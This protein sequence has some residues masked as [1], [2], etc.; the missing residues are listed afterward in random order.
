MAIWYQIDITLR[1]APSATHRAA[2][3]LRIP[4][5]VPERTKG[6]AC[7]AVK[8]RVQIPPGAQVRAAFEAGGE[9]RGEGDGNLDAVARRWGWGAGAGRG[10]RIPRRARGGSLRCR[11]PAPGEPDRGCLCLAVPIGSRCRWGQGAR[12]Q[13][14]C[15]V[16][17]RSPSADRA[18]IGGRVRRRHP[19]R[20]WARPRRGPRRSRQRSRGCAPATLAGRCRR[21]G[22]RTAARVGQSVRA[23]D[24][25]PCR[26]AS[27]DTNEW[28][29]VHGVR[30]RDCLVRRCPGCGLAP[31]GAT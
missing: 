9:R 30:L 11:G 18:R 27:R 25:H 3:T 8:P 21:L 29:S 20:P 10:G 2:G 15:L 17:L 28:R 7:K 1:A 24:R 12:F 14:R 16:G 4:A 23:R 5:P 13:R 19:V 6:T 26:S 22:T 31:T